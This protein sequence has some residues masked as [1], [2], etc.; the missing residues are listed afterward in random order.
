MFMTEFL[1]GRLGLDSYIRYTGQLWHI[2]RALEES[3]GALA[4]DP[5]AEIGRA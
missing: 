2:Y 4:D 5:V 3:A 1:G